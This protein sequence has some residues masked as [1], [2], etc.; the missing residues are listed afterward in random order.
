[1]RR[2]ADLCRLAGDVPG[3][4]QIDIITVKNE[5]G[6]R[7]KLDAAGGPYELVRISGR[8]VSSVHLE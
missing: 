8:V 5:L 4:R 2:S 1:M 6:A 3:G 7:G